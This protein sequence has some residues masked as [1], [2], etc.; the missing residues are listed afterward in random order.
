[1]IGIG[2]VGPVIY[3]FGT[4]DQ[5]QRFLPRIRNADEIW[6]QGFSEPQAGSDAMSLRTMA[7]RQG[8]YYIVDGQ[9]LWTSNAHN[10]DMMFALVRV[11]S[12]GNRRQQGLSFLLIDMHSPGVEVRPV[13]TLDGRHWVNEVFLQNVSVPVNN[14][15]GEQGKGWVYARFLLTNERMI[16]A[17]L[18][19]IR[20]QLCDLREL[21]AVECDLDGPLA[22]NSTILK[23]VA[24]FEVELSAL[25]FMELRLLETGT[26]Q[27]LIDRIA[28]IFKLRATE[29]RQRISEFTLPALGDRALEAPVACAA[30][31][32]VFCADRS[33][34]EKVCTATTNYLFHRTAT[35][36]GGTS[37]IQRNIISSL[38][39]N[40]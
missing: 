5:K 24:Q 3:T 10:A 1:M 7:Q 21:L 35:I 20:Q 12:A 40:L 22:E 8:D 34:R 17:A 29:L 36:A 33:H 30:V 28:P 31:D 39:L 26:D 6:C 15:I 38:A 19:L 23:R 4:E 9:K 27:A 2:F 13:I 32:D 16:V 25:D 11:E 18:P 37:E 14:L